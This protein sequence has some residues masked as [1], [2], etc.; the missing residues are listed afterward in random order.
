MTPP[1]MTSGKYPSVIAKSIRIQFPFMNFHECGTYSKIILNREPSDSASE[2]HT[3][4][5]GG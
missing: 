2:G 5:M 3:S 4:H 1:P